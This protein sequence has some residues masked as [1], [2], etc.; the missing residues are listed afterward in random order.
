MASWTRWMPSMNIW[1]HLYL[2]WYTYNF[3]IHP[4]CPFFPGSR[5]VNNSFLQCIA[6]VYNVIRN[7]LILR[8]LIAWSLFILF[9]FCQY[10]YA[11]WWN[12]LHHAFSLRTDLL[13]NLIRSL[14]P[15]IL[16]PYAVYLRMKRKFFYSYIYILLSV[17]L[18]KRTTA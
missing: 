17:S 1:I 13:A 8:A 12:I 9:Y 3:D 10:Y 5:G 7:S 6:T 11:E 14:I 15:T 4:D 2:L 16:F 18:S